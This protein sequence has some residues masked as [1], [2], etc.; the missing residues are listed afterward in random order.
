MKFLIDAQLP[1]RL[2][3][4]L[5]EYGHDAIHTDDLPEQN[6]TADLSIADI[7]DEENRTVISKDGDFLKLRILQ[8]KPQKLLMNTT[9]NIVNRELLVLFELNFAVI[10]KLFNSYDVVEMNNRFVVGHKFD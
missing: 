3:L 9:G 6:L 4:R 10:M 8:N 5:I 7:A 1:H 2:K